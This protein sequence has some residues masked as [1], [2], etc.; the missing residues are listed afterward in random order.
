MKCIMPLIVLI[1][2]FSSSSVLAGGYHHI[3]VGSAWRGHHRHFR[4]HYRGHGHPAAAAI[5]G[6]VVG[7]IIGSAIANSHHREVRYVDRTIYR[8]NNA[9]NPY[10]NGYR[11]QGGSGYF[12]RE[13][14][15]ECFLVNQNTYGNEVYT[16]VPVRNC[17]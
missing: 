9:Y 10:T 2:M 5:G 14:N 8:N 17:Q 15:G 7:G 4:P 16:S 12:R 6:L 11:P 1:F 3:D 13:S